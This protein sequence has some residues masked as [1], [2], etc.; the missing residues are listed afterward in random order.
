MSFIRKIVLST[1]GTLFV[2]G[3]FIFV[4]VP[5]TLGYIPGGT[6]AEERTA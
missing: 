3:S 2:T 4:S 6:H 1:L 5:Y